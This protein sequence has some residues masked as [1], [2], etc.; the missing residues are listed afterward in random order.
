M[1]FTEYLID[2]MHPLLST[3]LFFSAQP[4]YF[5]L[6]RV[7]QRH[8]SGRHRQWGRRRRRRNVLA[9]HSSNNLTAELLLIQSSQHTLTTV[10][11][12]HQIDHKHLGAQKM[13]KK[14]HICFAYCA[15]FRV[16]VC[17][18]MRLSVCTS[19][20]PILLGCLGGRDR[21]LEGSNGGCFT[22]KKEK[23]GN[24][25]KENVKCGGT[26]VHK[27]WIWDPREMF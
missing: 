10:R 4:P 20:K 23:R 18:C 24:G 26:G 19:S 25:Y 17:V 22:L 21:K 5:N 6:H 16:C 9:I 27:M 1:W 8:K 3:W 2:N 13:Q 7:L 15:C 11:S 14:T 12:A